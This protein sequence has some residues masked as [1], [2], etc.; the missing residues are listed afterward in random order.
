MLFFRKANSEPFPVPVLFNVFNRPEQ[1]KR[2][3]KVIRKMRPK[4]LYL[5]ADGP[6]ADVPGDRERCL[7]VRAVIEQVDWDCEIHTLF[8]QTNLGCR[9]AM[10]AGIDWFFSKVDAGIIL[11]DDCLPDPSFFNFCQVLLDKYRHDERVMMISGDNFLFGRK[12]FQSSYYFS[13]H[14][15]IWGWATWR[16]AWAHY[17]VEMST[18]P[19]FKKEDQISRLISNQQERNHWMYHFEAT[20]DGRIDTWDY[21]WAYQLLR[22]Q[23]LV[24]VPGVNLISNIG[25]GEQA[26]HTIN[27]RAPLANLKT[28]QIREIVHPPEVVLDEEADRYMIENMFNIK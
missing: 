18:F 27:K 8:Y 26:T 2:V 10:S 24:A 14:S 21:Q 3:F 4:S 5:K 11:E 25:H 20:Y 23:A 17:D 28:G 15:N 9:V 12:R 6:R 19:Q 7:Q 22:R 16:R 13:K 1:T